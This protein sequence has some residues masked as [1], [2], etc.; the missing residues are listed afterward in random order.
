VNPHG[1]KQVEIL[2]DGVGMWESSRVI[3]MHSKNMEFMGE[4]ERKRMKKIIANFYKMIPHDP[5]QK[6]KA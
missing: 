4:M 2:L 3:F 1:R 5:I 6:G